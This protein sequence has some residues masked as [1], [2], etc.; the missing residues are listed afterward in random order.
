MACWG[1]KVGKAGGESLIEGRRSA[2]KLFLRSRVPE[3]LRS[4]RTSLDLVRFMRDPKEV[5]RRAESDRTGWASADMV[6]T[7]RFGNVAAEIF[8]LLKEGVDGV[9]S[10][11]GRF[12]C[13]SRS[14]RLQGCGR[15][16]ASR[17]PRGQSEGDVDVVDYARPASFVC[18]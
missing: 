8:S 7:I 18:Q 11:G 2:S 14:V 5:V 9:T 16:S 12:S 15:C 3:D 1:V 4:P 6:R 10:L 17:G 13:D